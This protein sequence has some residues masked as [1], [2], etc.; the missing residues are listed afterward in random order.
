MLFWA[1]LNLRSFAAHARKKSNAWPCCP[2]VQPY[3]CGTC[4]MPKPVCVD[5]EAL[6]FLVSYMTLARSCCDQKKASSIRKNSTCE[7]HSRSNA[8]SLRELSISRCAAAA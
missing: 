1:L 8:F 6:D 7:G 2:R 4:W 3:R 5:E